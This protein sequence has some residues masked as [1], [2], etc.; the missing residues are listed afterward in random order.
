MREQDLDCLKIDLSR[1]SGYGLLARNR[2]ENDRG[3]AYGGVA[4]LWREAFGAFTEVK[5]KNP[6]KYEVLVAAGSVRGHK[7]KLVVVAAYIPPGYD[8]KRGKG[9]LDFIEDTLIEVKRRYQDPFL[10]IGGDF[11]QWRIDNC[12]ANFD[13]IKEVK[14][15]NTRGSRAID[16]LFLNIHRSVTDSGT[17]SPLETE[18]ED[19]R[20]SDH[21]IVCCKVSLRR[22][23]AFRWETYSYRHFNERSTEIFREWVVFHDWKEVLQAGT[24]EEKAEAYQKTVVG[25]VEKFY[26]LRTIRRKNTDPPWLDKKTKKMIED[27]KEFYIQEGGRTEAWKQEKKKTN[28]AVRKRKRGFLDI[29]KE[30]LLGSEAS[31]NFYRQVRSFAEAEKPK[32][33]DVRDMM[34]H[35]QSDEDTAEELARYFNRISEEFNPLSPGDIPCT[36]DK[37]MPVLHEYKVA[38]RIRRFKKP[39]STVP[40][41]IFPQLVTHFADFLAVPLADIFNKITSSKQWP[42]CWKKE[43]VTIIPKKNCPESLADLRNISCTLL[44]SKIYESYVL[45]WIKKEV[46]LRSNQYGGVKG[47]STDHLLVNLWQQVL[48]NAEDYRTGT[49][50]T[51]IDYSKAFNRMCY[52]ECLAALAR[53]GASSPVLELIATFLTDREMMVKVGSVLSKPRKVS[54]GCPQGSILGVFLFNSTIDDLEEGCKE[55]KDT[56]LSTRRSQA[57]VPSTPSREVVAVEPPESPIVR[58]PRRKSKR[59]NFTE[60]LAVD[61]PEEPNHWTEARWKAAVALFLRFIDDGFCLSKVNFENS[62]GFSINGQKYRI[63]HAVQAQNVFRHVVRRAEDL[64]MVV[65]AA[66]TA[67]ICVSGATDFQA[68]AFILDDDQRR[69]GCTNSIKELG[70]RFSN[71]LDMEDHVKYIAK[72]MRSRYWTLRNLKLNG[73]NNEELVHVYKTMLRPVAEY[74]CPVYHSSLTDD[75]DERLERLQDHALKCIFGTELLAR[76]LRGKAGLT[77]LR[78][79]REEFVKKFALKCARDPAFDHWFPRRNTGRATRNTDVYLEERARCERLKNSPIHYFRRI[80]NGKE[81]KTHGTRNKEYREDVL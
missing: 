2:E 11:N 71:R 21:R 10:V 47:L 44:A 76:R 23:E 35:G 70:I 20:R 41:D 53:N 78:E 79:R 31:R 74:G 28:D 37:D 60:E 9:A 48:E 77:T 72:A 7:R 63:K 42:K 62:L 81:G 19:T 8:T 67:M 5:L 15:G 46:T 40:G 54:G 4:V 51:S 69:I 80:L 30:K 27:R 32:M 38:S 57:P 68:D 66:K 52:Q 29:Q 6:S 59:L 50:I 3:V 24:A 64:G 16:R 26:P 56:R 43:Y 13:N 36:R 33:F 49:V 17:L 75:Q 12:L 58:P 45:D 14:V 65:N 18:D 25:A 73:F 55:L 22:Q 61:V 34:P 1:G 39:R